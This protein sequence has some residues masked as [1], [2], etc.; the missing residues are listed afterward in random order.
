MTELRADDRHHFGAHH[1]P[2][3]NGM[4]RHHPLHDQSM[5]MIERSLNPLTDASLNTHP[6]L[7]NHIAELEQL[8][9]AS[10]HEANS[11]PHSTHGFPPSGTFSCLRTPP[12][13]AASLLPC[14]STQSVP[15]HFPLPIVMQQLDTCAGSLAV[16]KCSVCTQSVASLSD[17][18]YSSASTSHG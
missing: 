4:P 10:T 12:A 8:R 15:H 1:H 5:A 13:S 16:N 18:S 17:S 9:R 6:A 2:H 14:L 3:F 7:T 11:V